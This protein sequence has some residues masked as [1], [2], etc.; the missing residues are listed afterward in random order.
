MKIS[1]MAAAQ[2]IE[3][4]ALTE[5]NRFAEIA[6]RADERVE[7]AEALDRIKDV[8]TKARSEIAFITTG[9]STITTESIRTAKEF[10]LRQQIDL[11][12]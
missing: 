2:D 6:I 4:N 1:E 3:K 12:D 11:T 10:L 9:G 7:Y 5:I 8:I